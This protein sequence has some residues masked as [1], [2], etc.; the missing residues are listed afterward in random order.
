[1]PENDNSYQ[2]FTDYHMNNEILYYSE[3]ITGVF[4]GNEYESEG[5]T[6]SI[7]GDT[8]NIVEDDNSENRIENVEENINK[9]NDSESESDDSLLKEIYTRQTFTSF[10][11]I[12]AT[13]VVYNTTISTYEWILKQTKLATGNLQST[14]IFTNADLVIQVA[15]SNCYPE[16]IVWYYAFH[17]WQNL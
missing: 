17:I 7:I 8:N 2:V 3:K 1:M 14:T 6:L 11:Q 5:D 10:A 4:E 13:A 9:G 16:T 12:V 15:I